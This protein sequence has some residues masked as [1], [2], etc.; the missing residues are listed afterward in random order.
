MCGC[1]DVYVSMCAQLCAYVSTWLLL[2]VELVL[3]HLF[4]FLANECCRSWQR[5]KVL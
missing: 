2:V 3:I 4:F 5:V 1:V